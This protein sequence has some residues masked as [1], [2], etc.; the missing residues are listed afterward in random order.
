MKV[1]ESS[2]TDMLPLPATTPTNTTVPQENN[3]PI[4]IIPTTTIQTS[5]GSHGHRLPP[6]C[7]SRRHSAP[8]LQVITAATT[9]MTISS[10]KRVSFTSL[11]IRNY[12]IVIGDHPCCMMGTPISLGWDYSPA[13][14]R[15]SV[16]QYEAGRQGIRRNRNQ[17]RLTCDERQTILLSC[18][19]T[20][21]ADLR[22]AGRKLHRSRSCTDH[23]RLTVQHFFQSE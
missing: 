1:E 10:K 14:Q 23:S 22:K 21:E 7:L 11:E 16:D 15:H 13:I 20:S 17:L 6:S 2:M 9:S 4:N 5:S 3:D 12:D 8:D 18:G 19:N